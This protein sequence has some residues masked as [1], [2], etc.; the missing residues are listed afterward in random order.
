M[1]CENISFIHQQLDKES[2]NLDDTF[3]DAQGYVDKLDKIPKKATREK[4]PSGVVGLRFSYLGQKNSS[5]A[6]PRKAKK[7]STGK[8]NY[9]N[10]MDESVCFYDQK[11]ANELK[12]VVPLKNYRQ[13][14]KSFSIG[15]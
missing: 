6:A 7:E 1:A 13:K 8:D 9:I 15:D 3:L 5:N 11:R 12:S 4:K 14:S 10:F 2:V